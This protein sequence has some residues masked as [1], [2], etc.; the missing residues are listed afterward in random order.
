[1]TARRQL[2]AE[3]YR[4][5]NELIR[6]Q[7]GGFLGSRQDKEEEEALGEW[8]EEKDGRVRKVSRFRAARIGGG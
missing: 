2:A 5:R 1:M 6:S 7:D 3:Y 4:R 8:M